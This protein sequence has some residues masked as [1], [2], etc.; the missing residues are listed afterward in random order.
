MTVSA[1]IRAEDRVALLREGIVVV[2][3][4]AVKGR[5]CVGVTGGGVE[6][7]MATVRDRLGEDTEVEVLG[8]LPRRLVP[9][10]CVG[11]MEREASRLQVRFVLWRDEHVDEIVVA[12]DATTVAVLGTVCTPETGD[13]RE[14]CEVPCHVYLESPLGER[15]VVDGVTGRS[16]PYKNVYAT[17]GAR[18]R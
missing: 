6:R 10:P 9:R 11:H 3:A 5:L 16:V 14:A 2:E 12:E 7:V 4:A 18:P 1:L 13:E 15:A 8:D 17:L